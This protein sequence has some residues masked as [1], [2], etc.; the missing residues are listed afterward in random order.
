MYDCQ[1][2]IKAK[3]RKDPVVTICGDMDDLC[4]NFCI[5]RCDLPAEII[6]MAIMPMYTKEEEFL[7]KVGRI[8]CI[9]GHMYDQIVEDGDE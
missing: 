7:V 3:C 2:V 4:N 6:A 5:T 9:N 8:K 1:E